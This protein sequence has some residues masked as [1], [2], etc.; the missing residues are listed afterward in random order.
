[1]RSLRINM[2]VLASLV[3]KVI[4]GTCP[5]PIIVRASYMR[6]QTVAGDVY[7]DCVLSTQAI[8][9][10]VTQTHRKASCQFGVFDVNNLFSRRIIVRIL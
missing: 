7:L 8:S 3:G 1:M 6:G 10:T 2:R 4:A 5:L 9:E